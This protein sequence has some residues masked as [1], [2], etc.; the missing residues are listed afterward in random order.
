MTRPAIKEINPQLRL[1][2]AQQRGLTHDE[3]LDTLALTAVKDKVP[4]LPVAEA[5]TAAWVRLTIDGPCTLTLDIEDPLWLIERSGMLDRNNDDRL[6][7]LAVAV[8]KLRFRLVDARRRTPQT[9]TLEFEDEAWV[10]M[11]QHTK[12]ISNSRGTMTRPEFI[13]RM[14][15]EVKARD[16]A[17][18][19]PESSNRAPIARPD[20]P[21]ARPHGGTGFDDKAT[22]KIKGVKADAQQ[23]REVA[24]ALT[25]ADQ[26]DATNRP[27]LAL[28]VS[29]IGESG[30]RDI[31]NSAGSPYG[32]VFQALKTRKLSTQEQARSFLKG[33]NGFQQGGAIALAR[34]HP[35]MSPGE[36]ATR[37]EA[38]GQPGSFYDAHRKEANVILALWNRGDGARGDSVLSYKQYR[39]TRGRPGVKETSTEAGVRLA[40][41]VNWRFYALGGVVGFTSDDYLISQSAWLTIDGLTSAGEWQLPPGLLEWPTYSHGRGK[42]P[43]EVSMR[44]VA[45]AWGVPPGEVIA[46]NNMG[47]ITGRWIT[48]TFEFDLLDATDATVDLIKPVTPRKETAPEVVTG[49][50][51]VRDRN[52]NDLVYP[53][54]TH[55]KAGGGPAD[56]GSRS[57]AQGTQPG[58]QSD[59]AIDILVGQGTKVYAVDEGE[60][61][62]LGGHWDGTGRSNP[63]GYNVTLKTKKNAWFY[64]HLRERAADLRIGSRVKAGH[65]LGESGAANGVAHLHIASEHG[66]PEKLL[67]V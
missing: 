42:L 26:E 3:R 5:I 41:E 65:L 66:D 60:V 7:A 29:G 51:A 22:F 48:E 38:S 62:R 19:I 47:P 58:W 12:S 16:L 53:L 8:D 17:I 32:G 28:L 11:D 10:L 44:V 43:G 13:M 6:D 30:F 1:L 55:G 33:G 35:D 56:H 18:F 64:T 21:D 49:S 57:G 37:V 23:M 2:A 25:V 20:L 34:A 63:N 14:V 46:Y 9:L 24:T 4:S 27:R 45:D 15:R 31:P 40:R 52:L 59:N 36:I 67:D 39:F 61:I 50:R 54:A